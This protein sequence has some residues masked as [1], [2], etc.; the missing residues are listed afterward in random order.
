MNWTQRI[1]LI[2]A[3]LVTAGLLWNEAR[4]AQEYAKAK[5]RARQER[6][7]QQAAETPADEPAPQTP[8]PSSR[9]QADERDSRTARPAGSADERQAE[10]EARITVE[11]PA[12][13]AVFTNR[14]AALERYTLNDYYRTT[15][16]ETELTL[17]DEVKPGRRSLSLLRVGETEGFEDWLF[18]VLETPDEAAPGAERRLVFQTVRDGWRV[19]RT[20]LFPPDPAGAETLEA[21]RGGASAQGLRYGFRTLLRIE[22]LAG[23]ARNLSWGV[24]AVSGFLP[25]DTDTR[26]G[27]PQVLSATLEADEDAGAIESERLSKLGEMQEEALEERGIDPA[28][29]EPYADPRAN[30]VWAGVRGRFFATI[31][32]LESPDRSRQVVARHINL[33]PQVSPWVRE[34]AATLPADFATAQPQSAE[35][36]WTSLTTRSVA[37]GG[38]QETAFTFYGG[39]VNEEALAFEPTFNHLVSY[40]FIGIFEPISRILARVLGF[41]HRWIPNYGICIILLTLLLKTALHGLTRKSIASG[42]KMQKVQPILKEIKVKYKDDQRKLS[43]ETMRVFREHGVSPMGS[44]VPMLI[45]MPILFAL[46]GLFARTFAFRQATFIPG[47]VDDLSQ[48]DALFGLGTDLWLVGSTFNLLPILAAGLQY[49][50]MSMTPKSSDPQMAQQ[51]AMMKFM[52]LMMMVIFYAMPAGLVLYFTISSGYTLGEHWLIRR[53]LDAEDAGRQALAEA[54]AGAGTG[55]APKDEAKKKPARNGKRR[56]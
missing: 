37:P 46:F 33:D 31:L 18:D 47:W 39:P 36:D 29:A 4:R 35:I 49:L 32:R 52:P 40:S 30:L 44:C 15:E 24:R 19:T 14:G 5:E 54:P 3:L 17:L 22:N 38:V 28:Q 13:R 43:E 53:R 51:Q 1:V 16:H 12:F 26:Y 6:L 50:H 48:P 55:M 8:A 20:Y 34:N 11:T 2:A 42:H 27:A 23:E 45:Q 10:R 41:L 9:P 25:D 56:R 21:R 7:E